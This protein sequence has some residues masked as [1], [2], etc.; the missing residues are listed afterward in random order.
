MNQELTQE[1]T[2]PSKKESTTPQGTE[3]TRTRKVFIPL[4]D[5]I[6]TE[7]MLSLVADL[8][9]VDENGV[10]ITIEKNVLTLKGTV[11]DDPP[12]GFQLGY[13]EYGIGDYE[14]S[15]TLTNEIDR[16]AI[17]ASMKDGVLR[18]TFPKVPQAA[19]HK[20]AVVAG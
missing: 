12:A 10:D 7:S 2:T 13:E 4:V 11:N 14:R 19:A 16:N 17:H 5:I 20:V 3:R 18:V 9:G 6:E 15:F 1:T 8:P